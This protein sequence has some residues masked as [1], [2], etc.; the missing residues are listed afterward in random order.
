MKNI[1]LIILSCFIITA[2][3]IENNRSEIKDSN[4]TNNDN[5]TKVVDEDKKI[6]ATIERVGENK[7]IINW[8]AS[9]AW[10]FEASFPIILKDENQNII[11]KNIATA[12]WNWMTSDYVEFSSELEYTN[13]KSKYWYL[14][15]QNDNPSGLEEN[16]VEKN[17]KIKIAD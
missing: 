7:L 13:P 3:S 2:C 4:I 12:S 15:F 11:A 6:N 17:V 8:K 1:I 9:G 5:I 16:L 10:F 14:I